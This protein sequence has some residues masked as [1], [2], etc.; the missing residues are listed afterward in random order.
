VGTLISQSER[1]SAFL[2][3]NSLKTKYLNIIFLKI[4]K[5][6]LDFSPFLILKNSFL[7]KFI[8]KYAKS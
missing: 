6:H 2:V 1:G 8:C 4:E 3:Q 7:E 5:N